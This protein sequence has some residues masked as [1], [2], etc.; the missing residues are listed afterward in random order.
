[1]ERE[2][3]RKDILT[4]KIAI[5]SPVSTSKNRPLD[6]WICASSCKSSDSL[7]DCGSFSESGVASVF[8]FI[9]SFFLTSRY[10]PRGGGRNQSKNLNVQNRKKLET[11]IISTQD[12][13]FFSRRRNA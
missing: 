8:S 12:V 9:F 13:F 3:E 1:M 5:T 2:R 6:N 10:R 11:T 4:K 7:L